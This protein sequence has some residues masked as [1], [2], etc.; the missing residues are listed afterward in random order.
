VF[1]V[2]K[3]IETMLTDLEDYL[4]QIIILHGYSNGGEEKLLKVDLIRRLLDQLAVSNKHLENSVPFEEEIQTPHRIIDGRVHIYYPEKKSQLGS[5]THPIRL[6]PKLLQYLL[7]HHKESHQVYN[8]IEHFIKQVWDELDNLDFKTT[9]TGVT[10]CFTN[11]RFAANTLRN[12]GLLKF[13]HKEAFKT[14]ELSL[15]GFIVAATIFKENDWT[16][17]QVEQKIGNNINPIITNAW[18]NIKNF[19]A[20]V[21]TLQGICEEG[22][23]FFNTFD[24]FLHEAYEL[25]EEY[26][27][28]IRNPDLTQKE[29]QSQSEFKIKQLESRPDIEKF[30]REFALHL[31]I[32]KLFSN[33]MPWL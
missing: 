6:Q 27:N 23:R 12:Y 28:A 10:R 24:S 11:T 16:L 33:A 25:L 9:R 17:G 3:K 18:L 20:F 8:I 14:W 19:D 4:D 2:T 1:A 13:T 30:Y 29:K 21:Q 5:G 7:I 31:E 15:P 26:W 32:E 22:T